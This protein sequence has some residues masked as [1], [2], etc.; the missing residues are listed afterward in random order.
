MLNRIPSTAELAFAL[1][2]D[3]VRKVTRSHNDVIK[4]VVG[5]SKILSESR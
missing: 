3:G 4:T 1:T 2:L 5:T